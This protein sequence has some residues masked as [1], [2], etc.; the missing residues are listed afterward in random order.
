M[1]LSDIRNTDTYI[2]VQ[3]PRCY[4]NVNLRLRSRFDRPFQQRISRFSREWTS[5][6]LRH[7]KAA[8]Y[9]A[10]VVGLFQGD[11]RGERE[12]EGGREASDRCGLKSPRLLLRSEIPSRD[13]SPEWQQMALS[14]GAVM[15]DACAV[16]INYA[17]RVGDEILSPYVRTSCRLFTACCCCC[18][19]LYSTLDLE[20]LTETLTIATVGFEITKSRETVVD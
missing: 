17:K 9:S 8:P 18:C 7:R 16:A 15:D 10:G 2:V 6:F 12:R 14:R 11:E 4:S 20:F 19:C 13:L 3:I 5:N 1:R